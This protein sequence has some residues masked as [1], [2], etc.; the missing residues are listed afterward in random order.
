LKQY[1][2][3]Y[4]YAPQVRRLLEQVPREQCLFLLFEEFFA[5][6][7]CQF[8]RVLE[9]LGL[10][11]D[12][13]RA[14]FPVVNQTS[15]VRSARLDRLLRQPPPAFKA[16]RRAVHAVGFHPIRA[17]QRLNRVVGQKPPL[18]KSFREEL[19]EYFSPDIAELGKLIGLE[20][21]APKLSVPSPQVGQPIRSGKD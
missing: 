16:L 8:A 1:G 19:E 14:A 6:P 5:D 2:A 4:C 13:S 12:P 17:V 9:F 11:P 10:A 21:W 3:L 7:S 20:L 18:G 15:G